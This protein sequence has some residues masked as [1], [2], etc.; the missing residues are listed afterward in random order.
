MEHCVSLHGCGIP[1]KASSIQHLVNLVNVVSGRKSMNDLDTPVRP[2]LRP[3][4]KYVE[5]ALKAV[6]GAGCDKEGHVWKAA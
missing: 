1:A 4:A 5:S 3:D 2:P 6:T